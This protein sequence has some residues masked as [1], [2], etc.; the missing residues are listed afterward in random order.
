[1]SPSELRPVVFCLGPYFSL[2]SDLTVTSSPSLSEL[3]KDMIKE[4]VKRHDKN[5][6]YI[7]SLV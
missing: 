1:M 3:N 5:C 7:E 6:V 2:D 4:L